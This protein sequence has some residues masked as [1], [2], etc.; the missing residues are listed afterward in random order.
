M[1]PSGWRG[2]GRH[3]RRSDGLCEWGEDE[4]EEE[5]WKADRQLGAELRREGAAVAEALSD[6]STGWRV[7]GLAGPS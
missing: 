4:Q 3:G 5:G 2:G 7:R 6:P 1:P